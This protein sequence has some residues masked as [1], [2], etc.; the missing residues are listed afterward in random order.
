MAS[1]TTGDFV[2]LA[3]IHVY[4]CDVGFNSILLGRWRTATVIVF[5]ALPPFLVAVTVIVASPSLLA[6]TKPPEAVATD[7]LLLDQLMLAPDTVL[8]LASLGVTVIDALST[9]DQNVIDEGLT[10]TLFGRGR[11]DTDTVPVAVPPFLVAVTVIVAVP[12]PVVVILPP[13]VTV[14]TD[15]L[16]LD[17]LMVAPDTT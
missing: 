9:F 5:D 12:S 6:F 11:T 10:A 7:E 15:E 2:E 13:E 17:Q 14:A 1:L 16:L 3:P 4:V 8:P